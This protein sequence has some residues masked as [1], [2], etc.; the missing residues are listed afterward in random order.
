M[1]TNERRVTNKQRF[2]ARPTDNIR[3]T[4]PFAWNEQRSKAALLLAEGNTRTEAATLV[5][6]DRVT[7]FKWLRHPDF[8][9]EVDRLSVMIGFASRAERIRK[10]SR[11]LQSRLDDNGVLRSDKDSL[12]WVKYIQS[13]TDGVKLDLSKLAELGDDGNSNQPLA[14]PAGPPMDHTLG[15]VDQA[16]GDN[17]DHTADTTDLDHVGRS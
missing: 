7:V 14:L 4:E 6:V 12:D 2:P 15:P 1:S 10:A 3:L 5:G 9:S 17:M 13:E 11:V 16:A 8:N